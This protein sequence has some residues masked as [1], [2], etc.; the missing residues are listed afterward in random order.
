[1]TR[2]AKP[3]IVVP[4]YNEVD[5]IDVLLEGIGEHAP[6]ADVLFVD[7]N[8]RDGTVDRIQRQQSRRPGKIHLL[9]RPG[10][11]G[12][13]TAYVAGFRWALE[14]DYDLVLLDLGLPD[15]NGLDLCRELRAT[16]RSIPVIIL[17]ARDAPEQRVRGLDVGADDYVAKPIDRAELMAAIE[18][19]SRILA[20]DAPGELDKPDS[21]DGDTTAETESPSAGA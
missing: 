8:S 6:D 18:R 3:L 15:G 9:Q 1:M 20:A 7:D 10:K 17:T 14:R 13:G 2:A 19:Q 4:T 5:N 12:L 11:M 21:N 16:G